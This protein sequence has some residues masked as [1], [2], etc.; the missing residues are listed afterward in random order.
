MSKPFH[1]TNSKSKRYI[2]YIIVHCSATAR[3]K[4][5]GGND[6]DDWHKK[7]GWRGIGY[8]YVVRLDGTVDVGRDESRIGA[9]VQGYN[10]RSIGVCYIGGCEE[11]GT[12]PCDTRT[13]A[14]KETLKQIIVELKEKYPKAVVRGHRDFVKVTT[15]VRGHR[16]LVSYKKACPC[17]DAKAEYAQ[18]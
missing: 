11:D 16:D 4:D 7:R 3:G 15:V 5:F 1:T 8:H 2:K 17:Y 13:A 14:Q 12:T 18:C 9:H 6:I 10:M